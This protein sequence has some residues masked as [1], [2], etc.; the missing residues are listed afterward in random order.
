MKL[1]LKGIKDDNSLWEIQDFKDS[2]ET[3]QGW[4]KIIH[5]KSG[6]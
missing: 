5:K 6:K 2:S 3:N 1:S 4:F